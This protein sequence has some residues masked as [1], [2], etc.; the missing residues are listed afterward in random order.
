[1]QGDLTRNGPAPN[2]D[3]V[4]RRIVACAV[5]LAALSMPGPAGTR[6]EPAS[7][8]GVRLA[9]ALAVPHVARTT[10][11]AVALDLHT[12][13]VVFRRNA[14]RAL[15]PAS[16][17]KLAVTYAALVTLGPSFRFETTVLGEGELHGSVWRGDLVLKG[18]G[19][20]TLSTADLRSLVRQ[21]RA[22]GIRKVTG[23]IVG[24]ESFFDSRRVVRG[25]KSWYYLNQ[26][27]SLS[28]LTVDRTVHR[29]RLS[30]RPALAAA[31][32]LR[33]ELRR[34]RVAVA[35]RA[36]TGRADEG[37]LPLASTLSRP[38][39][40]ILRFMNRESDNFTSE[41]ILKQL[42]TLEGGRG[43]TARGAQVVRRALADAG[44][45]LAGVRIA[46]G[47]GLSSR[48][49][50]TASA[51][52]AMLR[53]AWSDAE[54]RPAFVRSLAVAG[55]NGTLEHRMQRRPAAGRVAAK[56]GTTPLASA[57]S[58]FVA[59]RFAFAILHNGR[60]VSHFWARRAQDRFAAVLASS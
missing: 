56:T 35:G 28:A 59:N 49:R 32:T 48:N 44:V 5:C 4:R 15:I 50:L 39:H 60:P 16:N 31:V 55:R 20:P 10:S 19:D 40:D 41:L 30:T 54:L 2:N 18:Y 13:E 7:S 53:T 1:M 23:R 42:G 27:A 52:I 3:R 58:G 14:E 46:D 37:A 22:S 11:S 21:L 9:R 12:G 34:L 43:T 17:E 51:L 33:D 6:P 24:D 36:V 26:S 38:L 29:G 47:S 45:P 57:L 8:L 25:W